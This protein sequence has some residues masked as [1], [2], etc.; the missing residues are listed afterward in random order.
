MST[1]VIE[2]LVQ[3]YRGS[4]PPD[5]TSTEWGEDIAYVLATVMAMAES[6]SARLARGARLSTATG[7]FLIKHAEDHGLRK[8]DGET[9]EQQRARYATPPQA[10]TPT[11][12]L[13][14][15]KLVV[16]GTKA[17][18]SLAP[19]TT[20]C[21]TIVSARQGGDEGNDIRIRFVA[22][23]VG[24][25][26]LEE[27]DTLLTF[28]FQPGVTT[29]SDFETAVASSVL[30]EIDTLDGV[31]TLTTPGDVFGYQNLAGGLDAPCFLIELPRDGLYLDRD[32]FLDETPNGLIGGNRGVV[33]VL[34]PDTAAALTSVT[35][36][37]RSKVSAGK[38]YF[39]FEY[40]T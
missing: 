15:V 4:T 25:G 30:I 14:A 36:T 2:D 13:D 11:N 21:E 9:D 8:Q 24:D 3:V 18:L 16:G 27:N 12:I 32:G 28:H 20:N 34:I 33:I 19:L 5:I 40:T 6:E 22:D 1:D 29:V 7:F 37:V 39:I 23:G 35:D 31:G 17:T 10:V 38:L 26:Y